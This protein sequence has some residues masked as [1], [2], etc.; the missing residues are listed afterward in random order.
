[1]LQRQKMH[2]LWP[3]WL[4]SD[5]RVVNQRDVMEL[6]PNPRHSQNETRLLLRNILPEEKH[7]TIS[8]RHLNAHPF[9]CA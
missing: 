5:G 3:S 9:F 6:V 7:G 4:L 1:M 2:Q 8:L